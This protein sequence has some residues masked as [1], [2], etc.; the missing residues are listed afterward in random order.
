M[1]VIYFV[2]RNKWTSKLQLDDKNSPLT[3]GCCGDNKE[4]RYAHGGCCKALSCPIGPGDN[5]GQPYDLAGCVPNT[6]VKRKSNT[7]W[8]ALRLIFGFMM[9]SPSA[10]ITHNAVRG[11]EKVYRS[12]P[13]AASDCE[14][15][16]KRVFT[17]GLHVLF[18]K[19]EQVT[20]RR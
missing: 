13:I 12:V 4:F 5:G 19:E 9:M 7:M 8:N 14:K 18:R 20:L 6:S 10:A 2:I 1:G 17:I 11:K 15:N 3:L 16:A